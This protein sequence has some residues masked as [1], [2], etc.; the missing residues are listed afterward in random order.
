MT[1]LP[2]TAAVFGLVML[3]HGALAQDMQNGPTDSDLKAGYCFQVIQSRTAWYCRRAATQGVLRQSDQ[4]LCED[5]KKT[6][7]RLNDYLSARGY[8]LGPNDSMPIIIAEN[9]G[10]SDWK[11]CLQ[12][13]NEPGS[14]SKICTDRCDALMTGNSGVWA[15][16]MEACPV[17]ETC[18]RIRRCNDLTFLPF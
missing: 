14:E 3:V 6:V 1:K 8:I 4:K 13:A 17:P 10:V 11:G 15:S 18:Q 2:I 5:G 9:R 12:D 16:C 7:E